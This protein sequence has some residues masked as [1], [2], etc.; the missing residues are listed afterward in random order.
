MQKATVKRGVILLAAAIT[1]MG[2]QADESG[3]TTLLDE[4]RSC[5]SAVNGEID[6]R[7]AN[8]VR[9]V[10]SDVEI[11]KLGYRVEIDTTVTGDAGETR[12]STDC[13]ANRA[14]APYRLNVA[15]VE[16]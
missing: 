2:A 4:V 13:S 16:G 11:A 8:R 9:H 12:Y 3:E 14:F 6:T 15:E 7:N 5:I 10:V 1:T